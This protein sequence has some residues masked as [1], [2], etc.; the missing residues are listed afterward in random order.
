MQTDPRGRLATFMSPQMPPARSI[1]ALWRLQLFL[2]LQLS[3]RPSGRE[4]DLVEL[5]GE[6]AAQRPVV[7]VI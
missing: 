5:A 4:R 7:R 3:A 2:S 1:I 6:F